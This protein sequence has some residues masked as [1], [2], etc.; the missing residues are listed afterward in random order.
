MKESLW[1]TPGETDAE[2]DARVDRICDDL[3]A[4]G[5]YEYIADSKGKYV[6]DGI[7]YRR[8]HVKVRK[9]IIDS[10][11]AITKTPQGRDIWK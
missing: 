3:A 11:R 6:I 9:K 10:F 5:S 8:K 1:R 7:R 2:F 4:N